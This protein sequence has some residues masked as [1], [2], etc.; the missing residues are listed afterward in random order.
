MKHKNNGI[1]M[2]FGRNVR[3]LRKSLGY[4]QEEFAE[5][6]DLHRTYIGMV[7]RGEKNITLLNIIAFANALGVP[8]EKMMEFDF[9][10]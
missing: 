5:K 4:S 1:L 3:F 7:E 9:N 8:P 10:G 6:V 2:A